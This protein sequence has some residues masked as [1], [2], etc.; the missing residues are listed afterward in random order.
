MLITALLLATTMTAADVPRLTAPEVH[1][2]VGKGDAVVIDVR[3]SVPYRHG[4]IAGAISMPLGT[5]ARRFSELPQ[6]K[7]IVTYCTCRSEETS[8]EAALQLAQN[9]G[10]ERVAVLVG[11]LAAWKDAGFEIASDRAETADATKANGAPAQ[12]ASRAATRQ[13]LA[14]P[15]E[16]RCDRNDLTSYAGRVTAYARAGEQVSITIA[17]DDGTIESVTATSF[18][19][20][21]GPFR[22]WKAIEGDGG[23]PLESLRAI[24]WVCTEGPVLI[25]W[26]PATQ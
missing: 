16:V 9:H 26:R 18:L 6:E 7:T 21:G 10:F 1:A 23:K 17:T 11:G 14:P 20:D 25:D 2:L 5:I 13:R 4:R 3:G 22:G 15:P 19:H 24:A 8:L 12:A